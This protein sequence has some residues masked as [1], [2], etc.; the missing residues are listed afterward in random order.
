M[1]N[2]NINKLI[3]LEFNNPNN[4]CKK[5]KK[6]F[7]VSKGETKDVYAFI[8]GS[9]TL[10]TFTN[11]LISNDLN[12]AVNSAIEEAR[13][14]FKYISLLDTITPRLWLNISNA[15]L[16]LKGYVS[17]TLEQNNYGPIDFLNLGSMDTSKRSI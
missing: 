6:I 14:R 16:G 10:S 4:K 9:S 5:I 13:S 11:L 12:I 17:K 2:N 3:E 1:R 7:R 8:I 15:A